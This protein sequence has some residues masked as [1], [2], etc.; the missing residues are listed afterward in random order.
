[1][2]D[3]DVIAFEDEGRIEGEHL[4]RLIGII[5]ADRSFD[6]AFIGIAKTEPDLNSLPGILDAWSAGQIDD[7]AAIRLARLED[8]ADLVATAIENEVPLPT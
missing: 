7:R 8:Y 3:Q 1:M 2:R 6:G 5:S 4:L